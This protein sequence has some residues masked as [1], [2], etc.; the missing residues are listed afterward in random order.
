MQRIYHVTARPDGQW[1]GG[2]SATMM[3]LFLAHTQQEAEEIM[4]EIAWAM[5]NAHV[6][7][8]D[9]WGALLRDH[10]FVVARKAS[11]PHKHARTLV[12]A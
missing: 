7:V 5:G 4:C 2:K 6:L 12:V 1:Q 11:V 9:Q 8:F 10:A 3:P